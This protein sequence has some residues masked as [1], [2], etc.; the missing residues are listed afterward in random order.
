MDEQ[1]DKKIFHKLVFYQ[2]SR[3]VVSENKYIG[4]TCT[5]VWCFL[6]S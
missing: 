5:W 1:K 3:E 2:S 4:V 6:F